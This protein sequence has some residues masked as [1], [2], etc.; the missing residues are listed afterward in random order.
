MGLISINAHNLEVRESNIDKFVYTLVHESLHILAMS[1][2]LYKY[3]VPSIEEGIINSNNVLQRGIQHFNC[4]VFAGIKLENEGGSQSMGSHFEKVHFGEEIMT[5]QMT[6]K[7]SISV[8]TLALLEDTN[9][10]KV[11]YT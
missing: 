3:F 10:Y 2:S 7:P 11:D 6:G 5:A 4:G 1:P 8:F 9:W